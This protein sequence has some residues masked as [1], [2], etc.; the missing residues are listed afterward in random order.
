MRKKR[1][2][3]EKLW[4]RRQQAADRKNAR[5]R[6]EV[7]LFADQLPQHTAE[8]EYWRWRLNLSEGV[9]R[10]AYVEGCRLL[11]ILRLV[12]VTGFARKALGEV[13]FA[14]LDAHCRQVYRSPDYWYGFWC[15]V[16]TGE[17][18]EL[19]F[20]RVE[21]R[22]PGQPAVACTDWYEQCHLSRE[23]FYER[24]PFKDTDPEPPDDGGLAAQLDALLAR[25]A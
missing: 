24:F 19:A 5:L 9:E 23:E 8:G 10:C 20:A 1:T 25:Y 21:N 15:R 6:D 7:P 22:Q 3:A 14:R 2:E 17:R 11:G 16:L 12:A 18:I 13:T 4:R